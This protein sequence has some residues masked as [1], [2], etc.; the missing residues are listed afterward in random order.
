MRCGLRFRLFPD[1][2]HRDGRNGR[3]GEPRTGGERL[4]GGKFV[5][6]D[7]G[8]EGREFALRADLIQACDEVGDLGA[9]A[10]RMAF[11]RM[12]SRKTCLLM[13]SRRR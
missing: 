5:Q 13:A 11:R 7:D 1:L 10:M 4:S 6:R 8:F 12:D 3:H 2:V 9:C